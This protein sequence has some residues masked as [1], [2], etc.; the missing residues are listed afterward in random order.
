TSYTPSLVAGT[1]YHWI[2][3][4]TD[5]ISTAVGPTWSFGTAVAVLPNQAPYTP[6]RPIPVN[7]ASDI[8]ITQTLSWQGGDPDGDTVTYTIAIN[9]GGQP[10]VVDTSTLT[11]YTPSL[12]AGTAYHW[13]VTATDGISTVVG[14]T[15]SFG[16]AVAVLPNQAPYTPTNPIP[17]NS[18]SDVPITQTL[19]WQGGDPDGDT[20]TYT[21]VISTSGYSPITNTTTLTSYTP[22]LATNTTYY[23]V[24]TAT[25]GISA[26]TGPVWRFTTIGFEYVYL[27]LV[28]RN[29]SAR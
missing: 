23:W 28:V 16:T 17:A 24:I 3:T 21:V 12:V 2:I 29:E 19:S 15:W 9:T 20:V 26:V 4:A 25:D 14:P 11:S 8:P 10:P 22:S 5:G 1:A 27:P 7:S 6:T 13:I 18:A